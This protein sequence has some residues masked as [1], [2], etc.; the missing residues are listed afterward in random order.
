MMSTHGTVTVTS[1]IFSTECT[2]LKMEKYIQIHTKASPA[3]MIQLTAPRENGPSE[4]AR[5]SLKKNDSGPAA[6]ARS[7]EKKA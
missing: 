3:M 4:M 6:Y 5:K 1:T 7:R 2:P